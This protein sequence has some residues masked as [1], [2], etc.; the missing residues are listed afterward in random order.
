MKNILVPVDFSAASH[1]AAKYAIALA[2]PFDARVT[3]INVIPPAVIIDDSVLAF[4]MTTQ[5]E[6]LESHKEL[7]D[8]EIEALSGN[9]W[10]KIKGIVEEGS[11]SEVI[12]QIAKLKETDIIVMGMKGKGKSNSV[13]GSTTTKVIRKSVF[14]VF[15]I[16]EKA[17]FKP[18]DSVTFASDF[19]DEIG[20]DRYSL[21]VDLS[22]KF[23][24]Q[25]YVLNVQENDYVMSVSEVLG[26]MNTNEA[27]SN[28]SHEFHTMKERNVEEGINKFIETYPTDILAMVA[29]Q[30]NFFERMVGKVH[31]KEMSYQTKI[32]LLV[33]QDK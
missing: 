31:T 17:E 21:L 20:L 33:L 18:I 26:K 27:F 32:P 30:H 23:K 2:K 4:V 1:N 9:D 7:M 25:I 24:S 12:Q 15:V 28:L 19:D 22:E 3:L 11:T 13:F 6:I 29:H 5:A 16:P 14:P 8:K 10:I